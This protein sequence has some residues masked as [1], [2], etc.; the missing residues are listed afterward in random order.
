MHGDELVHRAHGALRIARVITDEQAR[1]GARSKPA[2]KTARRQVHSAERLISNLLVTPTQREDKPDRILIRRSQI[3]RAL[4]QREQLARELD[5]LSPERICDGLRALQIARS[6]DV[7]EMT[8]GDQLPALSVAR[9]PLIK[10]AKLFFSELRL[11]DLL[12]H[13]RLTFGRLIRLAQRI[14]RLEPA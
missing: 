10:L 3:F 14:K 12:N 6:I 9:E 2:S 8:F 11:H 13:A 7:H 1:L 5:I 4:G